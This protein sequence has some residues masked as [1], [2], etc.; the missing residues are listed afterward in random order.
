MR[1]RGDE[2]TFRCVAWS[3]P[4]WPVVGEGLQVRPRFPRPVERYVIT[5]V[6]EP[7]RA[8]RTVFVAI[9]VLLGAEDPDPPNMREWAWERRKKR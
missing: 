6:R 8:G 7:K 2:R 3:G 4:R 1:Q 5:A 9:A